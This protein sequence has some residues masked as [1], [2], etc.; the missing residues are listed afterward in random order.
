MTGHAVSAAVLLA[1]EAVLALLAAGPPGLHGG[2]WRRHR[3]RGRGAH[4]GVDGR[5]F[6]N[7]ARAG[8][9]GWRGRFGALATA[10][11]AGMKS[12]PPPDG[13]GHWS[14]GNDGAPLP[15]TVV[16]PSLPGS[17][18]RTDVPACSFAGR[19]SATLDRRADP[20]QHER[21]YFRSPES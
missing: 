19:V 1:V 11:A 13:T 10:V 5:P 7:G 15:P 16:V 8:R 20:V 18:R 2:V 21:T 6:R 12:L 14:P 4:L 17:S 3:R 9:G